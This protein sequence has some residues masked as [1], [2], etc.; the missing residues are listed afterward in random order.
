MWSIQSAPEGKMLGE[1]RITGSK[2]LGPRLLQGECR[3]VAREVS[4]S[5]VVLRVGYVP[6]SQSS[7]SFVPHPSP[8]LTSQGRDLNVKVIGALAPKHHREL[9]SFHLLIVLGLH[10]L[11]ER[12]M[13]VG[14]GAAGDGGQTSPKHPRRLPG[15][16]PRPQFAMASEA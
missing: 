6:S 16:E 9:M 10:I 12:V 14:G 3:W 7:T 13:V 8:A 5:A 15:V 4:S 1:V 2:D 11:S